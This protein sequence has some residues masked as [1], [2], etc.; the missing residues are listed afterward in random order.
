MESVARPVT[1]VGGDAGAAEKQRRNICIAFS[2]DSDIYHCT[3]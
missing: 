1:L 2:L 3:I